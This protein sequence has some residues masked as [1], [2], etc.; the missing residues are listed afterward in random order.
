MHI[1]YI[2]ANAVVEKTF[3]PNVQ[4]GPV[5]ITYDH[6]TIRSHQARQTFRHVTGATGKIEYFLTPACAALFDSKTLPQAMNAKRHDIIHQIIVAGYRV[7]H[8]LNAALLVIPGN[9]LEAEVGGLVRQQ[10]KVLLPNCECGTPASFRRS[11]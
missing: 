1:P 9:L 4:H 2:A 6:F 11:R 8:A 3:A 10:G 7:K 5:N